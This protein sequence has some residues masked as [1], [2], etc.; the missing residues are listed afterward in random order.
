MKKYGLIIVIFVF[1]VVPVN[2]A[3]DIAGFAGLGSQS[4]DASGT[5]TDEIDQTNFGGWADYTLDLSFIPVINVFF[6][7]GL[8]GDFGSL[9]KSDINLDGTIG[10]GGLQ[11]ILGGGLLDYTLFLRFGFGLAA[12][13]NTIQVAGETVDAPTSGTVTAFGIGLDYSVVAILHL[14]FELGLPNYSMTQDAVSSSSE[15]D[16]DASATVFRFGVRLAI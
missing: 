12:G 5:V 10:A 6:G 15:F 16:Y 11:V 1:T 13:T 7:G 4:F 9:E 3:I 8:F 14:F 2:A